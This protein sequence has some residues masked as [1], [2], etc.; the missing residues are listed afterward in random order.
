[1]VSDA[2]RFNE[3]DEKV[4]KRFE[5]KNGLWRVFFWSSKFLKSRIVY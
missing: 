2:E 5:V 3:Q 4:R 1:M